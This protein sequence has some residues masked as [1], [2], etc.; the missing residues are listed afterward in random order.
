MKLGTT[1]ICVNDMEKSMAFYQA[2]LQKKPL[3]AN[4]NRWVTF[5]C[6]NTFSLY[7]RHYDERI[8]GQKADEHFNQAYID[9]FFLDK[10]QAKN[11]IMILNFEV[12]D[13]KQ[14]QERLKE[15]K[16]G[17][18]SELMYVNVHM[19]YWYFNVEDPDG[20]II[21]ITGKLL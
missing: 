4:E 9:D 15:L 14:E 21:E 11:N 12:E 2:L 19:P 16:I 17:K 18:V 10:G 5:D 20:N 1:Y 13:L 6:G 8:I 3:Y 7:N